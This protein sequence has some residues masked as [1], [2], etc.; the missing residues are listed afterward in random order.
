M[1]VVLAMLRHVTLR[2]FIPPR[3]STSVTDR[4]RRMH[5]AYYRVQRVTVKYRES[6]LVVLRDSPLG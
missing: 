2:H 1:Q 3:I 5:S 6:S 4:R